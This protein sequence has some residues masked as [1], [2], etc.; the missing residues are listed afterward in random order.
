[1]TNDKIRLIN[2]YDNMIVDEFKRAFP[3]IKVKGRTGRGGSLLGE[4]NSSDSV[5][6]KNR[7]IR[8]YD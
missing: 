5:S 2:Q 4:V 8:F 6:L 3:G 1:M 7:E